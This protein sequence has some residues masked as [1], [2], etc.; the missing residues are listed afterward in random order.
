MKA[1]LDEVRELN[2]KAGNYNDLQTQMEAMKLQQT[3]WIR[4]LEEKLGAVK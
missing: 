3:R 2:E 1:L 4:I